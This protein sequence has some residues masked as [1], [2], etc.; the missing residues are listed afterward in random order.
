MII[1]WVAG[2]TS[3]NKAKPLLIENK[4]GYTPPFVYAN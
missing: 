1:T 2:Y 3:G 4:E